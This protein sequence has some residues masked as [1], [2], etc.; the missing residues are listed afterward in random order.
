[1]FEDVNLPEDEALVAM[2]RD[3]RDAKDRRN[4]LSNQNS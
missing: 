3:L 2:S 1:M 4:A